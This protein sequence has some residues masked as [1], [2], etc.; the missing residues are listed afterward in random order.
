MLV[1]G[2]NLMLLCQSIE[3]NLYP[4]TS[5][6]QSPISM[7]SFFSREE[8]LGGLPARRASMLLFAIENRAAQLVA[9]DEREA[10]VYLTFAGTPTRE[11]DFFAALAQGRNGVAVNIQQLERY[12]PQ[13]KTLLPETPDAKLNAALADLIGKKYKFT[14]AEIPN[15]RAALALDDTATEQQFQNA[16]N[17]PLETIYA[18]R[19]G[20]GERARFAWTRFAARLENIPPFWLAFFLTMPGA[21]GLLA[22]PIA[23]ARVGLG[24]GILLLAAFALLNMFTVAALAE[25]T[26]RA[27]VTRLGFGWLG[28]LVQE[29]LGGAGAW[30]LTIILALNNFFVL[31]I[32]FLG[33]GG[34]L[35]DATRVPIAFWMFALFGICVFFLSRG[36]LNATIAFTL[37]IVFAVIF[38]LVL[39]PLLALPHFQI[40]NITRAAYLSLDFGSL[41]LAL[42][43]MLTTYFSHLLVATYTPVVVRKDASAR[44]WIGGSA[45]AIFG[46]MLIAIFW[47]VVLNGALSAEVLAA[48]TGTVL[49]PLAHKAGDFVLWLGS[50]LVISSLG[51]ATV[52]IALGLYYMVQERLPA[53]REGSVFS[54]PR[55]RFLISILPMFGV[56]AFAEW[57]AYN[58]ASSFASLLGILGAFALPLL[59]GI[60]P[61]LL[62]AATR[63]K[64]DFVTHSTPRVLGNSIIL[65]LV[66]A[67]FVGIIFVYGIFIFQELLIRVLIVS[68]GLITLLVTFLILRRGALTP[69]IVLQVCGAENMREDE[70]MRAAPVSRAAYSVVANGEALDVQVQVNGA[71]FLRGVTSELPAFADVRSLVFALPETVAR[72][73][74]IWMYQTT[75][76]GMNARIEIKN[77]V[78]VE[79]MET[80]EARA[81]ALIKIDG[82]A[83]DAQVTLD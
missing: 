62:L 70:N 8:L 66:Y 76:T 12:A 37:L 27:G 35:Q 78:R 36:S 79:R 72:E 57:L 68:V 48:T 17:K 81:G 63:H 46:F 39:L 55:A 73:I 40:E 19:A 82:S 47:L 16:F 38:L 50:L 51:L 3:S 13:W 30:F 29:Y 53:P 44:S 43:L 56:L 69:R 28:Q 10:A 24:G 14:R 67:L 52:Q 41:Q 22:M 80:S 21:A 4:P 11:Q 59:S 71:Q 83:F 20:F 65:G 54:K 77:G 15:V 34:T 26:A 5:N 31:V 7:S 60:F 75:G 61:I 49:T 23:L 2:L 25:A 18:P 45:A 58:S 32:F 1:H 42:G 6:L 33:V 64:G 9:Q 74:K